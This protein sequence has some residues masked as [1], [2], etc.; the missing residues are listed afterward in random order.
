MSDSVL[1]NRNKVYTTNEIGGKATWNRGLESS[2]AKT[3]LEDMAQCL[4]NGHISF[5]AS[6]LSKGPQN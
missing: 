2:Y 5:N 6:H 1:F 4:D 3:E